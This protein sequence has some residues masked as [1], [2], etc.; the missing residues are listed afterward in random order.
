MLACAFDRSLRTTVAVLWLVGAALAGVTAPLAAVRLSAGRGVVFG[1]VAAGLVLLAIGTLR[2]VRWVAAL[3][4]VLLGPQAI[5]AAGAA[6]ELV[7]G[8]NAAKAADL[9][10]VGYDPRLSV[11][12]NVVYSTVA[13]AV[14]CWAVVRLLRCRA[15]AV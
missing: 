11:A 13:F 7:L 9:R 8:V 1:L 3:D 6:L 10:A 5:G 15:R 2:G 4:L 12:I 14:F